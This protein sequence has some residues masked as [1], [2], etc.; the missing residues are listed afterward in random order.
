MDTNP[1]VAWWRRIGPWVGIGTSPVAMMTGGGVA[2]S[3]GDWRI[4]VASLGGVVLLCALAWTQGVLGTVRRARFAAVARESLGVAGARWIAAPVI[5]LMMVG[6][7]GFNTALAG[8]GL[9]EL[10]GI[11][12]RVGVVLFAG[13]MVLIASRGLEIL[14]HAA[15]VAGAATVFLAI[16][17]L[18]LALADHSG[19]LLHHAV[20]GGTLSMMSAMGVV[21]G[22]G[23][24][25]ALRTPDFTSDLAARRDVLACAVVGLAIPLSV[26][27]IVGAVLQVATGSWNL[28][29]VLRRVGSPA[30]GYGFVALGFTGSVLSN[31]HSGAVAVEEIAPRASHRIGLAVTAV[32]GTVL[33]LVDYTDRMI[34]FLTTMALAAPCLIAV[35]AVDRCRPDEREVA[36]RPGAVAAWIGGGAVGGVVALVA[37][38]WA[39][40]AGLV[41]AGLAGRA[42]RNPPNRD[43]RAHGPAIGS[44]TRP[45]EGG[46]EGPTG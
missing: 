22:Y 39:L 19:P 42:W 10:V 37:R 14:S 5:A 40:A 6:W 41:T 15:L 28:V 18:K 30:I 21:V 35:L 7:F 2:E 1:P 3:N 32:S 33:A 17:G 31:L 11:P 23:A 24:A 25:F 29:E 26:F 27:L 36:F 9:G 46:D 12:H 20:P 44:F 8:A 16:L 13:V 34:P 38:P 45:K 43:R 4:V